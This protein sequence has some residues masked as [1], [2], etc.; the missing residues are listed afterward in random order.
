MDEE[1]EEEKR[2]ETVFFFKNFPRVCLILCWLKADMLSGQICPQS[3]YSASMDFNCK[4]DRLTAS[5]PQM[6]VREKEGRREG[7]ERQE[8]RSDG[9]LIEVLTAIV[10]GMEQMGHNN[11]TLNLLLSVCVCVHTCVGSHVSRC[12]SWKMCLR[13]T[14]S[15]LQRALQLRSFSF[16]ED[17]GAG[18][19]GRA[20]SGLSGFSPGLAAACI[21]MRKSLCRLLVPTDASS[22][23]GV[24]QLLPPTAYTPEC[25]LHSKQSSGSE[26]KSF[27]FSLVQNEIIKMIPYPV[28]GWG[29]MGGLK[30][31]E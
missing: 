11:L 18:G 22:G 7:E 1:A 5:V 17:G 12:D 26:L 30:M 31:Y 25:P 6:L 29:G 10:L 27:L 20:H 8:T 24:W 15:I 4:A 21:E 23:E 14:S 3:R 19:E 9:L 2:I 28:L 13:T 16:W